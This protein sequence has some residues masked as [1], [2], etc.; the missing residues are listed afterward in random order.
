MEVINKV[1]PIKNNRIE[2]LENGLM[3]RSQ[4]RSR[5]H[6]DEDIYKTV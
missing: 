2:I 4:K 3:V 5:I 6:V 1:M